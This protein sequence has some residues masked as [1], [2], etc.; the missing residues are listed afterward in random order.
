M[1]K[2]TLTVRT[3]AS[4]ASALLL[5]SMQ[6]CSEREE[7]AKP[8]APAQHSNPVVS[9]PP[10][11]TSSE[12]PKPREGGGYELAE[13]LAWAMPAAEAGG[14]T[15]PSLQDYNRFKGVVS[16]ITRATG[17]GQYVGKLVPLA[18]GKRVVAE[19]IQDDYAWAVDIDGPQVGASSVTFRSFDGITA[20]DV[21]VGP[22]YLRKHGFDL[23]A[24]ICFSSGGTANNATGMYLARYAGRTPTLMTF[25]V[26][27]GSRGVSNGWTVHYGSVDWKDVPAA[28]EADY[29]GVRQPFARC[30]YKDLR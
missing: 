21:E 17:V 10:A 4:V 27:T 25:A 18:D 12:A 13:V 19:N 3:S 7:A 9:N 29:R 30:E 26:S 11:S 14:I 5:L 2:R 20:V 16:N 24:L 6:G 28:T 15:L 1:L 23:V 22:A 8:E